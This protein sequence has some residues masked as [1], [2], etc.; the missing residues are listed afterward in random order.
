LPSSADN[1]SD[2]AE[3]RLLIL[4]LFIYF[5]V[6]FPLTQIFLTANNTLYGSWSFLFFLFSLTFLFLSGKLNLSKVG[7][8]NFKPKNIFLGVGL[9]IVPVVTVIAIDAFIVKTGLADNKLF[10]GAELRTPEGYTF[11]DL[12]TGG[13]LHPAISQI[14]IT[15]YVLN[16][17][18][19]N[20]NLAVAGNGILYSFLSFSWGI[21]SL[22]LGMISAAL[23]RISGSL[24]PAI[25]FS[26]GCSSAKYLI[27]T[28]YPRVTTILVF[29]I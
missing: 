15:G 8:S 27:L 29:L 19:K 13:I 26:V 23:L 21:G 25:F 17:L 7:L 16:T 9:G 1:A 18:I 3:F 2:R 24:I 20:K 28:N 11:I 5:L 10:S 12:L 14:F 22:G 6:C 4:I